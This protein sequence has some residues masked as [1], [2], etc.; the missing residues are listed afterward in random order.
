[1]LDVSLSTRQVFDHELIEHMSK[2]ER[3]FAK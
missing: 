3:Q 1:M 2:E